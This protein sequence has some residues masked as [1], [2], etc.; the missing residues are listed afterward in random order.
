M[1]QI[2]A[3]G[4]EA[5]SSDAVTSSVGG[6]ND[7][8][9][10]K[11]TE[12]EMIIHRIHREAC[13]VRCITSNPIMSCCSIRLPRLG[14]DHYSQALPHVFVAYYICPELILLK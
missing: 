5:D 11:F 12:E 9:P 14:V 1:L 6:D 3:D 13:E 8:A 10:R 7:H 2:N 4:S